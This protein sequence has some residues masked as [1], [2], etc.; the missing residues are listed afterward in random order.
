M[1]LWIILLVVIVWA[2]WNFTRRGV[3]PNVGGGDRAE[4]HRAAAEP[5]GKG[6]WRVVHGDCLEYPG[7]MAEENSE[8]GAADAHRIV[9]QGGEHRLQIAGGA[10]D[11]SKDLRGGG[12]PL[13]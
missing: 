2:I 9:E 12:L 5:F 1:L 6:R 11:L 10:V 13:Q 4:L 3:G 8:P 7:G